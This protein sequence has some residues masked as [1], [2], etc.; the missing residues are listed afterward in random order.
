[1]R[2]IGR[3]TEVWRYPVS[4]VGGE[5]LATIAV[6]PTGIPGDRSFAL[7]DP[8]TGQAAAPEQEPRWRPALFLNAVSGEDGLPRLGFP[9]GAELPVDDR[10][11][12]DRLAEHFGFP[13]A[14]GA[15]GASGAANLPAASNRYEVSPL[16]I[17]TTASLVRLADLGGL[18]EADRRRF[19][20]SV[21]IET[22]EGEGFLENDWIGGRIVIGDLGVTITEATKRCG[23]TL[24]AQPGIAENPVVLQT[25]TRHNGRN[26]GVYGTVAQAGAISVGDTVYAE[27]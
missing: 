13:V 8:A 11:L 15:C 2:K 9:D 26:L 17:V 27:A 14:L 25:L 24:A 23:L 20:P 1:M 12:K 4:S 19:R 10:S 6:T 7:F 16:H 18:A 5:S 21:L 22:E 3:V